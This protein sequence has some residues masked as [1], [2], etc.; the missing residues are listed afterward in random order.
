MT[1]LRAVTF[2]AALVLA[3]AVKVTLTPIL[4]LAFDPLLTALAAGVGVLGCLLIA[5]LAFAPG[6]FRAA[7]DKGWDA[8]AAAL[9]EYTRGNPNRPR[10]GTATIRLAQSRLVVV[11]VFGSGRPPAAERLR[12]RLRGLGVEEL[13]FGLSRDGDGWAFVARADGQRLDWQFRV[14]ASA[15]CD[16]WR[17]AGFFAAPGAGQEE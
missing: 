9:A 14:L 6:R 4:G 3:V 17:P 15:V 2:G 8:L 1:K 12:P 7:S 5:W 16:T 10:R 11:G 13:G